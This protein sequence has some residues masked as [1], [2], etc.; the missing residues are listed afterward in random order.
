[1]DLE[2]NNLR[3]LIFIKEKGENIYFLLKQTFEL[4]ING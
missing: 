4:L 2:I 1:M 3:F